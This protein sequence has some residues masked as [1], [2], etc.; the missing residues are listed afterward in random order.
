LF[1]RPFLARD[2]QQQLQLWIPR[3]PGRSP[4]SMGRRV[5]VACSR[6]GGAGSGLATGTRSIGQNRA[7]R[8]STVDLG[9]AAG[10]V[11]TPPFAT[12][13]EDPTVVRT[14]AASATGRAIRTG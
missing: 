11:T 12:A 13:E 1:I 10:T 3:Q 4:G 9:E 5:H 6:R 2:P 14:T 7:D 8:G